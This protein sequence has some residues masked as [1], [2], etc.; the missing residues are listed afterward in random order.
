MT[1]EPLIYTS[2]GNMP[3]K[4]LEYRYGWTDNDVETRLTQEWLLGDEVVKSSVHVFLKHGV[5]VEA[6]VAKLR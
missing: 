1:D 5:T 6:K 2:K 3:I 4:D